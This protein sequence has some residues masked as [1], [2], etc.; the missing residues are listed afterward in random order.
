MSFRILKMTGFWVPPPEL[1][2]PRL[3]VGPENAFLI[4]SQVTLLLGPDPALIT[5]LGHSSPH[6]FV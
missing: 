4:I 2:I 6:L 5:A 1:W 3:E